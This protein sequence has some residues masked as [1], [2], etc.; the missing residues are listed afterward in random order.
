[1]YTVVYMNL[2]L[3]GTTLYTFVGVG[4]ILCIYSIVFVCFRGVDKFNFENS[5]R[6]TTYLS[7]HALNKD[8]DSSAY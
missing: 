3:Y 2:I 6:I 5:G 8:Y 4:I 7:F 1:M